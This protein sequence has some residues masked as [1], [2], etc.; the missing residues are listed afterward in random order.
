MTSRERVKNALENKPVDRIP[1]DNPHAACAHLYSDVERAKNYRYGKGL[2]QGTYG[3]KGVR[4]DVWGCEWHS[5]EDGVAGEVKGCRIPDINDLRG[6]SPPWQVLEQADLRGIEEQCRNTEKFVIAAWDDVSAQPFQRMQY[7]RGSQ[8]LYI[9]MALQEPGFFELL[10]LVHSYYVK[11]AQL[12]CQTAVDAIHIE[13]DWG[14]QKSALISPDMWRQYFKPLY[15][16]YAEIAHAAGKKIVMHSDGY[17]MDL[18]EDLIEIGIDALNLQLFCMDMDEIERRFGGRTAFWGEIDR[19][20]LLP[21]GS[22][23][24]IRA[25]VRRV[26]HALLKNRSTGVVAMAFEGKDISDAALIAVYDEWTR[27]CHEMY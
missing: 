9:D 24:E 13:D 1:F 16:Q 4:L 10:S 22:E 23:E 27:I 8:Q 17:T 18:I 19:Q 25:G 11:Q 6:F 15:R 12:W 21:F 2:Q 3:K 20:Y 7:L 5:A 26:Q 14:S